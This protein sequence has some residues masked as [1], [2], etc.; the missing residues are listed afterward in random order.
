MVRLKELD[1]SRGQFQPLVP[2]V[3]TAHDLK[4]CVVQFLLD[5]VVQTF[6]QIDGCVCVC[7]CVSLN[8]GRKNPSVTCHS[9]GLLMPYSCK[10]RLS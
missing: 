8:S 2:G 6:L 5:D 7:V 3:E 9:H 1:I 10:T 4:S